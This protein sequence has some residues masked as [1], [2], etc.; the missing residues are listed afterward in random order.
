MS[1]FLPGKN[2]ETMETYYKGISI[3][4][5]GIIQELYNTGNFKQVSQAFSSKFKDLCI[6]IAARS[7]LSDKENVYKTYKGNNSLCQK[8]LKQSFDENIF[9]PSYHPLK[10]AYDLSP[11]TDT[12]KN[13]GDLHPSEKVRKK[14]NHYHFS[15][16]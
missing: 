13:A 12:V 9:M 6:K 5:I 10:Q 7:N 16:R 11:V 8:L 1:E 3:P 2:S 14:T 4:Y 15:F